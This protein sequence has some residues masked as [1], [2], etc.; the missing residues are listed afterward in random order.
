[1]SLR[2][3][4]DV[5]CG[6]AAMEHDRPLRRRSRS[7]H[8]VAAPTGFRLSPF[9]APPGWQPPPPRPDRAVILQIDLRLMKHLAMLDNYYDILA[10][11]V[12]THLSND[13]YSAL[14]TVHKVIYPNYASRHYLQDLN[15]LIVNTFLSRWAL[16]IR[17]SQLLLSVQ[18]SQ[19]KFAL[20][21][22][23]TTIS[24]IPQQTYPRW[25]SHQLYT[26]T[27]A[28]TTRP[29][30][31]M[32]TPT[33]LHSSFTLRVNPLHRR[34]VWTPS[35]RHPLA[36]SRKKTIIVRGGSKSIV[37]VASIFRHTLTV[38]CTPFPAHSMFALP[39]R[40]LSSFLAPVLISIRSFICVRIPYGY[41]P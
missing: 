32:A 13:D 39:F 8:Q 10:P 14:F 16:H 18:T 41:D 21:H 9:F 26:P 35:L 25:Q 12:C 34:Q 5:F 23:Q 11:Q 30:S 1:M 4:L 28:P 7:P 27:I 20:N 38:S 36:E 15:E 19:G 29:T 33:P 3:H 22:M 2:S 37:P 31:L 6:L 24:D 40:F 17:V